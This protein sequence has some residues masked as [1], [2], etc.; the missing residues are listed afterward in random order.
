[1]M[2]KS[3]VTPA[4]GRGKSLAV[5]HRCIDAV[6]FAV[7]KS[8]AGRFLTRAVWKSR[9]KNP[10]E[11]F[12]YDGA[13]GERARFQIRIDIFLLDVHIMV[14]GESRLSVVVVVRGSSSTE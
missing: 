4:V 9:I 12:H 2:T 10:S 1:M 11:F 6:V 13:F 5:F 14:F 3:E 7:E 8:A